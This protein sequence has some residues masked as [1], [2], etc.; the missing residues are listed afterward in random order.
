M[1]VRLTWTH[2]DEAGDYVVPNV[3]GQRDLVSRLDNVDE[4][5][6]HN[7]LLGHV[8]LTDYIHFRPPFPRRLHVTLGIG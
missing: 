5:V 1:G 6:L 7:S 8:I 2:C 4:T 3:L